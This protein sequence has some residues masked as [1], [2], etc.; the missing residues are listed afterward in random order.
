LLNTLTRREEPYHVDL[1]SEAEE[2]GDD[3]GHVRSIHDHFQ[4]KERGLNS[5]LFYDSYRR[6][7]LRDHFYAAALD[8]ESL[9]R[10]EAGERSDF[11]LKAY[12]CEARDNELVLNAGGTVYEDGE[13]PVRIQKRIL[14]DSGASCVRI[15]YDITHCGT[16][17]FETLFGVEFSVNFLTGSADDRYYHS[18]ERALGRPMLGVR[19]VETGLKAFALRDEWQQLEAVFTLSEAGSFFYFPLET[20]SQSECGQERVHQ[21]SVVLSA[22]VLRLEPGATLHREINFCVKRMDSIE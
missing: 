5:L 22:W 15:R 2:E 9:Y 17:A 10:N 16:V 21:G 8:V 19:G 11:P 7:S 13:H 14:L 12:Q 20:V 6:A 4:S 3:E 18:A 1:A